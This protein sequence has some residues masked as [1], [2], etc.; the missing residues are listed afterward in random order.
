MKSGPVRAVALALAALW[1]PLLVRLAP[2]W[3]GDPELM[4][5]WAVP[6]LALYLAWER[7][8]DAP[9][10]T[11]GGSCPAGAL[12]AGA[13]LGL[14][15]MLPVLEA[16]PFW[17][18]ALWVATGLAVL[19]TWAGMAWRAGWVRA[20]HFAPPLLFM[21][22]ALPWPVSL[23]AP[24]ALAGTALNAQVAAEV[25]SLFGHP[26]VVSGRVIEVASGVVGIEEA[27]SGLR[28][29]QTVAMAALFLGELFRLGWRRRL[30]LFFAALLAAVAGNL[31]RTTGLTWLAATR[32]IPTMEA[33]HDAAGDWALLGTLAAVAA[34]G[35]WFA[36][37]AAAL[38]VKA[39]TNA[40]PGPV[41]NGVWAGRWALAVLA[42]MLAAEAGTR[43]WF[44]RSE[45]APTRVGWELADAP[46]WEEAALPPT[47]RELLRYDREEG[48]FRDDAA[49]GERWL[50]F[51]LNWSGDPRFSGGV[52]LHDPS[53][54]LPG[55][56]A[57]P[58][59]RARDVEVVVEGVAIRFRAYRFRAGERTQRVFFAVWDGYAGVV[60]DEGAAMGD[61][62]A[63]RLRQVR[64]GRRG[65]DYYHLT[66]VVEGIDAD[67]AA[68]EALRGVAPGLLR[69]RPR[70]GPGRGRCLSKNPR[71]RS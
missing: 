33:R 41:G 55:I 13:L 59:G 46:G 31:I 35:W 23:Q 17:P 29:L 48:R 66:F 32:D 25:V 27:C 56:G 24:V 9:A 65:V 18:R 70:Q 16:N 22:T 36:R 3:R 50:A 49:R 58:E 11:G 63:L 71:D 43:A 1:T 53:I 28:S 10:A 2:G 4:H 67:A 51:C 64:E 39:G 37:G 62:T 45:S 8:H 21:F 40:T 15:L 30:G 61:V 47:A 26:A 34:L 19:A 44:A 38:A 6:A 42:V 20:T 54:C 60:L 5:G 52:F 68:D 7:R 57:R 14:A 69:R 12:A